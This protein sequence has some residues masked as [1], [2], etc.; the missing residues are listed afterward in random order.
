MLLAR[1]L[2]ASRVFR[3]ESM[4]MDSVADGQE[5]IHGRYAAGGLDELAVGEAHSQCTGI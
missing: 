2:G 1:L 4:Q 3:G 5:R